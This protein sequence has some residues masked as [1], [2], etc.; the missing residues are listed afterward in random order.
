MIAGG[1]VRGCAV[2]RRAVVLIE[3]EGSAAGKPAVTP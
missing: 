1:R 3:A 2:P